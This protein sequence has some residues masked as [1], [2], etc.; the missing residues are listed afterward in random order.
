MLQY[1][2]HFELERILTMAKFYAVKKGRKTGIFMSWA[3]CEAQ[4]KGFPGAIFKSFTTRQEALSFIDGTLTSQQAS[5]NRPTAKATIQSTTHATLPTL[6]TP[7]AFVDGS[8]NLKTKTYGY[9]GFLQIDEKTR[10]TLQGKGTDEQKASMRNVAGEIDGAMAA[11]KTALEH[12]LT[13]I[14]IL[15]DYQGIESWVTGHWQAKNDFTQQYRDFMRTLMQQ[16]HVTFVKVKGHS[17]IPGNELAD[18]L[19]KEAVGVK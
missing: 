6:K 2:K 19:A 18:Q 10:I 5:N 16:I 14:T 13:N 1:C 7:Y 4:V 8:Y 12:E 3:E 15:Y 17:G 11:V 9:G